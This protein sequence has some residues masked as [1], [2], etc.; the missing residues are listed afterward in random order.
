MF[1]EQFICRGS[2]SGIGTTKCQG[3]SIPSGGY[4]VYLPVYCGQALVLKMGIG[5]GEV[6]ASKKPLHCRA[7]TLRFTLP[8][9]HSTATLSKLLPLLGRSL[10][11]L[12]L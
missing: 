6:L 10:D 5:L 11:G 2:Q 3:H 9:K 12:Q 8:S 4:I 1:L 7:A